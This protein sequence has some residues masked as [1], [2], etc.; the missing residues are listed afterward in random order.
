MPKIKIRTPLLRAL[1]SRMTQKELA[2]LAGVRQTTISKLEGGRTKGIDFATLAGLCRAL[3][4]TPNDLFE[5]VWEDTP[6][7]PARPLL[8]RAAGKGEAEASGSVSHDDD[9]Y[10]SW[11]S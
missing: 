4:C 2:D 5:F 9:L 3:N 1:R 10:G 8:P 7:H 11:F 6:P